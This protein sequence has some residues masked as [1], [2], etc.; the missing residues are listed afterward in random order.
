MSS[1]TSGSIEFNYVI[2]DAENLTRE[3]LLDIGLQKWRDFIQ[4]QDA[5][6]P[7]NA[8]LSVTVNDSGS[9]RVLLVVRWE[10]VG[11]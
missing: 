8:S 9:A 2:D 11:K 4:D 10:R 6:F 1:D 3:H 5:S 7:W